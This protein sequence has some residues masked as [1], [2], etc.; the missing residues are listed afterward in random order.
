MRPMRLKI[1]KSSGQ[2]H[3]LFCDEYLTCLSLNLNLRNFGGFTLLSVLCGEMCS[4]VS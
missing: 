1:E 4:L 3:G 2:Y